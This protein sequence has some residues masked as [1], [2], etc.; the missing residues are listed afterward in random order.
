MEL[1]GTIAYVKETVKGKNTY[2]SMKVGDVWYG[3]GKEN[4]GAKGDVIEFDTEANGEYM[5]AGNIKKVSSGAP[6]ASG[7]GTSAQTDW[8]AKDRSISWQAARNSAN[9][10]LA[11]GASA[12]YQDF[13]DTFSKLVAKSDELTLKFFTSSQNPPSPPAKVAQKKPS[14]KEDDEEEPFHDDEIPF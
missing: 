6:A 11:V 3:T 14:N 9:A 4:P 5:N 8:P 13:P 7:S 1:K 2:Y 10:L 12:G